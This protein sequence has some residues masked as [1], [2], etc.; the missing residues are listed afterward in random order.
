MMRGPLYGF[1]GFWRRLPVG[2]RVLALIL[3]GGGVAAV[4][5]ELPGGSDTAWFVFAIIVA[6]PALYYG[7]KFWLQRIERRKSKGFAA[8]LAERM[9]RPRARLPDETVEEESFRQQLERR[10]QDVFET[11]RERGIDYYGLPW[12][13]VIGPSQSG[14]TTSIQ[15][16]SQEFPV[17]E[18]PVADYGA[19]RLQLVFT[20]RRS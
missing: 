1:R 11:L 5:G 10:W 4:C 3:T 7:V 6:S 20:N 13:L 18:K 14:K 19:P 15:K 16:S 9:F 17:G 2:A 12:Y 8:R